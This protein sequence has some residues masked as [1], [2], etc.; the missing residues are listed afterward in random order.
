MLALDQEL[1]TLEARLGPRAQRA[2]Q[3]YVAQ[4]RSLAHTIEQREGDRAA[5]QAQQEREAKHDAEIQ[6]A[7]AR[8]EERAKESRGTLE[9]CMLPVMVGEKVSLLLKALGE[10]PD[11][12]DMAGPVVLFRRRKNPRA[13]F[14]AVF[15]HVAEQMR[16]KIYEAGE[17]AKERQRRREAEQANSYRPSSPYLGEP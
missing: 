1:R 3:I 2:Q 4:L 12:V 6:K 8:L 5:Q 15:L 10:H 16:Q 17:D 9:V 13:N 11:V 14:Q 7:I